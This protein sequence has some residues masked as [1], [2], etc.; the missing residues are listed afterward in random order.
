[1]TGQKGHPHHGEIL[2]KAATAP[3]ATNHHEKITANDRPRKDLFRLREVNHIKAGK[4]MAISPQAV[5][6]A[7]KRNHLP[8]RA[9]HTPGAL[10][11]MMTGQKEASAANHREGRNHLHPR[12]GLI[13]AA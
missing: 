5:L 1:M 7:A 8:Q 11:I 10:L 3:I 6:A 12:A 9:G 2:Q 4:A 13:Q